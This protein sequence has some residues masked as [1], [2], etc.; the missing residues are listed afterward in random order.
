VA[1]GPNIKNIMSGHSFSGFWKIFLSF[2]EA[3]RQDSP[4][5]KGPEAKNARVKSQSQKSQSRKSQSQKS[6]SQEP[7]QKKPEPKARSQKSQSQEPERIN[8]TT[9]S[10]SQEP[11][12]TGPEPGA[13]A[14]RSQTDK[15]WYNQ[16]PPPIEP[17]LIKKKPIKPKPKEST[18]EI[19]PR[20][21]TDRDLR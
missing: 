9:K 12:S 15:I 7:E 14:K 16:T 5:A 8:K 20:A 6:Q 2:N 11:E 21:T 4:E 18:I 19:K 10:Q 1:T 3:H 13:R 17:E